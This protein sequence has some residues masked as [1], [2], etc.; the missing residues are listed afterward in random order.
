M[1][2]DLLA[3][4]SE[5]ASYLQT[6]VD[7]TTA[8]LALEL[9]TGAVQAA[10]G[11][12]L[13]R[14][15]DDV[16]VLDLDHLDTGL[17]LYLPEAPVVSVDAVLVGAAAVTDVTVQLS[18]GRLYRP[19]GWRSSATA[20]PYPSSAPSTATVTYTHGYELT[21]QELQLAR[22]VCLQIASG[23]YENAIGATSEQ[24]DDYSVRY[25]RAAA[26]LQG[27]VMGMALRRRYGRPR[28]SSLLVKA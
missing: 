24:I 5:L 3:T 26:E 25:E 23:L 20:Y 8:T 2:A 28:R 1:S 6:D 9:A 27:S 11:Q 22:L 12:R 14:V 17:Y 4:A 15:D 18:R 16:V 19:S 13:I 7:T 21:A 10:A